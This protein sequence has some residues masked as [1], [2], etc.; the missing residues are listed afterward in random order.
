MIALALTSV[1]TNAIYLA[2]VLES[3]YL[4]ATDIHWIYKSQN[5]SISNMIW[6][7]FSSSIKFFLTNGCIQ[8]NP[9]MF[10]NW[11]NFNI[12]REGGGIGYLAWPHTSSANRLNKWLLSRRQL[13]PLSWIHFLSSRCRKLKVDELLSNW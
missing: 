9:W 3:L 4:S 1:Y 13:F 5:D 6:I 2:N 12:F 8:Y 7:P 10:F 11:I